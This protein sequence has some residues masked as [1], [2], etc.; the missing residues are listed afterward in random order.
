MKF[1]SVCSGIEAASLAWNPIGWEAVGFAEI[2]PF[3]RAVLKHRFPDIQNF[4]DIRN[5]GRWKPKPFDLLAGGT[6]CQAFSVAGLRAGLSDPRG[7]LA[8][9][10]L[11]IVD[12]L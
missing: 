1:L 7:N 5:Y 3:A 12:Q 9:V 11:G 8:L 4:G 2:D 10:F 6:P